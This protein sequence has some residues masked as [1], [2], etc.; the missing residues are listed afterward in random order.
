MTG[1]SPLHVWLAQTA[2]ARAQ[3]G[4]TRQ[5]LAR[6]AVDDVLDLAGNDYLGLSREPTVVEAA[7]DAVRTWGTGATGSRLVTGTTQLH[8]ELERE[9][10]AFTGAGDALV[11]ATGYAANLAVVTALGGEGTLVV[12]DAGNH[13]SLI[14]GCRLA[15]GRVVVTPHCDVSAVRDALATRTEPRA[16]VVTDAVFS[17]DGDAAPLADL[18]EV[19]ATHGGTL[20]V[21][22]AHALG[23]VGPGGRGLV[24][25]EGLAPSVDVIRT[26]TLSKALGA[27]GGAV[28]ATPDVV[29]HL[30]DTARTFIFD[31]GLAP[32]SVA[33]ALQALRVLRTRPELARI[34]RERASALARGL[35]RPEPAA[36]IVAVPVPDPRLAVTAGRR[37]ASQGVRVG[38][39]RPPS[40]PDGYSRL[41]LAAR[42]TLT[43]DQVQYVVQTVR[44]AIAAAA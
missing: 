11:F 24:V 9:L 44:A 21:D 5:L 30:V 31:T 14:D 6:P 38:C 2:V 18:A 12:S 42:A 8:A 39:F 17:V 22:E 32:A 7:I 41:R 15:R 36:A 33:A 4:L 19:C 3:Q 29:T 20:V 13:A 23:V 1:D 43:A 27:Q 25:A 37:C 35:D 40:V 28:L 34:V 10:A 26:V 16:L